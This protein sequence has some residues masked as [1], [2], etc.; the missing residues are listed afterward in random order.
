[1]IG[2]EKAGRTDLE[3]ET[4]SFRRRFDSGSAAGREE[5][6]DDD[7]DASSMDNFCCTAMPVK[8]LA[9]ARLAEETG[10]GFK[11]HPGSFSPIFSTLAMKGVESRTLSVRMRSK[12]GAKRLMTVEEDEMPPS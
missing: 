5:E 10:D 11:E 6:D 9:D 12:M 7:D 2:S 1:M 8:T 3:A 4:G